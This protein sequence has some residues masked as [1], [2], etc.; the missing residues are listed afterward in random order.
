VRK[1]VGIGAGGHAKVL[2]DI[3][4]RSDMW[5]IVGLTDARAARHGQFVLGVRVLGDDRMLGTLFEQGVRD[6][7]VGVGGVGDNGP[8]QR[9]FEHAVGLGFEPCTVIHPRACVAGDAALGRGV[10]VFAAGIINPGCR[11]GDNVIVNT[12]AV[13]EHDCELEAHV[14]VATGARLGGGVRIGCAAHIGLGA[15]VRQ[16]IAIGARAVVGAGAVVVGDVPAATTVVG[17]PA[18]PL[19]R[20]REG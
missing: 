12:A 9:A 18:R 7:F 20:G 13:I 16:G 2:V 3:L 19:R 6:C 17:V 11:I 1:L 10:M 4:R 14:H 15:S 8:R 5:E